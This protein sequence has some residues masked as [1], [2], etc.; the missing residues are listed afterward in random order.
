MLQALAIGKPL[1]KMQPVPEAT[2]EAEGM[3]AAHQLVGLGY[4][5]GADQTRPDSEQARP[6][7]LLTARCWTVLRCACCWWEPG[8]VHAYGTMNT[9]TARVLLAWCLFASV[10][11]SG[12]TSKLLQGTTTQQLVFVSCFVV[13]RTYK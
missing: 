10:W 9:P 8:A 6:A 11:R 2:V 3:P 7:G 13:P 4:G 1:D 12:H 5:A